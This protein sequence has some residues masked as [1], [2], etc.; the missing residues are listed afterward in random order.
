MVIDLNLSGMDG[1]ELGARLTAGRKIPCI[2]TSARLEEMPTLP[3]GSILLEKPFTPQDLIS[4][5]GR[6]RAG[7]QA[8]VE[9]EPSMAEN[10][11]VSSSTESLEP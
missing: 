8:P 1:L 11:R 2:Y 5:L 10:R 4:A 7:T 9:R 3:E 6:M